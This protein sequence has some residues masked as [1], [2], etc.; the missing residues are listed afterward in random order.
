MR[1]F[2]KPP[3]VDPLDPIIAKEAYQQNMTEIVQ[4][5]REGLADV[6]DTEPSFGNFA[7]SAI[8]GIIDDQTNFVKHITKNGHQFANIKAEKTILDKFIAQTKEKF[9]EKG[10]D[11]WINLFS[12]RMKE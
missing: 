8:F 7:A 9:G 3:K 4:R 10:Y 5:F 2:E 6:E 11:D 1:K 12:E